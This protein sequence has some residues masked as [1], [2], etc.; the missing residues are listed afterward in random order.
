MIMK[1]IKKIHALLLTLTLMVPCSPINAKNVT[2]L[3][4]GDFIVS[5]NIEG[6]S[7]NSNQLIINSGTDFVIKMKDGLKKTDYVIVV[8]DR[9][10]AKITME[11]LNVESDKECAITLI[12]SNAELVFPEGTQSTFVSNTKAGINVSKG[13]KLTISGKGTVNSK[14]EGNNP[15]IGSTMDNPECGE[16]VIK[17]GTV[18]AQ[19]SF[20]AGIGG[21]VEG[22]GATVTVEDGNVNA[23]SSMGSA[24][25][26]GFSGEKI[27]GASGGKFTVNN[28]TVKASSTHGTGIGGGWTDGENGGNGGNGGEVIVN[29]GTINVEVNSLAT[30]IGG[31]WSSEGNGGNGGTFTMNDGE[32]IIQAQGGTAIGGGRSG[33][34]GG[35]GADV[36]LNGGTLTAKTKFGNVAIGGGSAIEEENTIG[37]DAGKLTINGGNLIAETELNDLSNVCIVGPGRGATKGAAGKITIN[38]QNGMK[39]KANVG[40]AGVIN[41]L[42]GS[43]FSSMTQLGDFELYSYFSTSETKI[44]EVTTQEATTEAATQEATTEAATQEVTT[45]AATQEVTTQEVTTQEHTTS[46]KLQPT[47]EKTVVAPKAVKLKKLKYKKKRIVATWKKRESVNGFEIQYSTNKKFKKNVHKKILSGV[48]YKFKA[49]KGKTYYVR[50]RAF[51]KNGIKNIIGAWSSVK[52]YKRK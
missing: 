20:G 2:T 45:E 15:G 44:E 11:N 29:G 7:Q 27:Q 37:G 19:S 30:G 8:D 12:N 5:G 21:C 47:T 46:N 23:S 33:V 51:R 6:I 17:E 48:S 31:G 18:N 1:T 35:A 28:G 32:V 13:S 3:E 24:I 52:R 22:N 40:A 50:V 36:I 34:K 49:K 16:I 38:P 25:G 14:A 9:D 26:A 42:E 43:P 41:E 10:N 4:C 39:I